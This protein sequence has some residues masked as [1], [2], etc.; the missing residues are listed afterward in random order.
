MRIGS[1]IPLDWDRFRAMPWAKRWRLLV[2]A[3]PFEGSQLTIA[4]LDV[5][6]IP[7]LSQAIA[8]ITAE[9]VKSRLV[10]SF[11]KPDQL[12][13]IVAGPDPD[14]LAGACVITNTQQAVDCR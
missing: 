4:E 6:V 2:R 8:Q 3:R 10:S 11:A 14:A 13:V 7:K 9:D 1:Y 12:I 5:T